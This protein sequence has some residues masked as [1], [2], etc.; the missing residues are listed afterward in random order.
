MLLLWMQGLPPLTKRALVRLFTEINEALLVGAF[1]EH[2]PKLDVSS[3]G[4]K[5]GSQTHMKADL[6]EAVDPFI[7]TGM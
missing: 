3:R 6:H 1:T 7:Q 5:H 4:P 2:A